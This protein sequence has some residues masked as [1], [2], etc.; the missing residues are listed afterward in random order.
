[1]CSYCGCRSIA[2][3]AWFSTEHD[4][5]VNAA[6]VL[7]RAIDSGDLRS[8]PGA[9]AA[10]TGLLDRHT[11]DEERTLF[12][13]MAE[14]PEFS[15]HI[16]HLSGEH[17]EIEAQLDLLGTG[18][19]TAVHRLNDLLR[20]HIEKGGERSVPGGRNRTRWRGLGPGTSTFRP[21][22][23]TSGR[24]VGSVVVSCRAAGGTAP[25]GRRRRGVAGSVE[26]RCWSGYRVT[27]LLRG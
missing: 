20:D 26:V 18:D 5:I 15:E 24:G 13:E 17:R 2:V 21:D 10:L 16:A 11:R 27:D 1:M 23:D 8:V 12:A 6:G 9:A 4:E 19:V 25:L 7:R 14:D 22:P 3:I